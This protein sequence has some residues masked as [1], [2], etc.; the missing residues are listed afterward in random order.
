M[1]CYIFFP[2]KVTHCLFGWCLRTGSHFPDLPSY[3]PTYKS[4]GC[5]LRKV[6]DQSERSVDRLSR[7]IRSFESHFSCIFGRLGLE[8]RYELCFLKGVSRF[9]LQTRW[10][11][12]ASKG[13]ENIPPQKKSFRA[14]T[15]EH[16]IKLN[17]IRW[18]FF[19]V[20]VCI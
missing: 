14:H 13:E 15:H 2:R 9:D 11:G 4:A 17:A 18:G 16:S 7:L 10:E 3:P 20:C 8:L 19:C 1:N 6:V 5:H 12:T